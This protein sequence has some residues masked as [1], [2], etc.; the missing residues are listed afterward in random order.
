[1]ILPAVLA[2]L[3]GT[4]ADLAHLEQALTHPSFAN[5]QK[6]GPRVDYQR[7][8]F[9]GDAVIQL[10]VSEA[11]MRLYPEAREGELSLLR[12]SVVST[13]ALASFAKSVELGDQLLLGRGADAA[14]ERAQP[15]VLA[16]AV[17]AV[18]GAVY[19]DCGLDA[20]RK[21]VARML[22]QGLDARAK[23]P[24]R[25]AK[26]ELQERV[27]AAGGASPRYRTVR[28]EGPPHDREFFVVV[29]IGSEV[30]AEGRGRSKKLAEV[31]AARAALLSP[32]PAV[33][34]LSASGSSDV[35]GATVDVV[36]EAETTLGT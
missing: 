34:T 23:L 32:W 7:L 3:A 36:K 20:A 15:N 24:Q 5:E 6:R 13:E 25:D 33:A 11:L 31:D 18:V 19:L 28:E 14:G 2:E 30:L 16:D 22:E 17:E 8:E 12:S 4:G 35:V 1:M 10:C 21:I 26:S 9:L 27:Q 29:E